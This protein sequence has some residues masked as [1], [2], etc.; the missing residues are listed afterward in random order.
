VYHALSEEYRAM[1]AIELIQAA[2]KMPAAERRM[3]VS[4]LLDETPAEQWPP[5]V[6]VR[7][8]SGKIVGIRIELSRPSDGEIARTRQAIQD[9]TLSLKYKHDDLIS[10][11]TIEREISERRAA[12]RFSAQ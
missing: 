1:T 9:G 7:D 12:Q 6:F 2:R 4:S 11:E 3:V 8:P 5:D 10:I